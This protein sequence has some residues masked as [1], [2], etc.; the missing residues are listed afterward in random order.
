[1]LV[2]IGLAATLLS[3][4]S[5][6]E[7]L[8]ESTTK[9]LDSGFLEGHYDEVKTIIVA[10][11]RFLPMV[12]R[13]ENNPKTDPEFVVELRAE[14]ADPELRFW[15][16]TKLEE[17][18]RAERTAAMRG[19][20]RIGTAEDVPAMIAG[21][22]QEE[23]ERWAALALGRLKAKE[24]VPLLVARLGRGPSGGAGCAPPGV[25]TLSLKEACCF[26]LQDFGPQ[27]VGSILP[28][29]HPGSDSDAISGA[30]RIVR[31][32]QAEIARD[33]VFAVARVRLAQ[34]QASK[35][36]TFEQYMEMRELISTLR[37]FSD[38]RAEPFERALAKT[39]YTAERAK[40]L[41]PD[42]LPTLETLFRYKPHYD[43]DVDV[44]KVL[45]HEPELAVDFIKSNLHRITPENQAELLQT[46]ISS[47]IAEEDQFEIMMLAAKS[48]IAKARQTAC[49]GFGILLRPESRR[50]LIQL[51]LDEDPNVR[52]QA[53]ETAS[54]LIGVPMALNR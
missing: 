45:D 28:L 2:A 15:C 9:A 37:Q 48:K 50:M 24:A 27:I 5:R 33:R 3:L 46:I 32:F 40:D 19:L 29:I 8:I 22:G 44:K 26:A 43:I 18:S 13:L 16:R 25:L 20:Y 10:R 52:R 38:D 12:R 42:P 54:I 17:G 53:T 4:P 21:L 31:R 7:R 36:P 30:C 47:K 51:M 1:M 41:E 23:T 14:C 49:Y 11:D 34:L 39:R 35:K 6:G